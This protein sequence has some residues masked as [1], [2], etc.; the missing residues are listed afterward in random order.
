VRITYPVVATCRNTVSD[1]VLAGVSRQTTKNY[2]LEQGCPGFYTYDQ[3]RI[4]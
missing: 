1:D 3:L 2:G 4:K